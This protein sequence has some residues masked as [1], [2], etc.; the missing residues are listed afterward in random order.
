MNWKI[1]YGDGLTFSDHNG[2]PA[3]SPAFNVQAIV[4]RD[5][6]VGRQVLQAYD[7]YYY[8][9]G[10]WHGSKGDFSM[11]EQVINNCQKIEAVR[12]GRVIRTSLFKEI[13]DNAINDP[14][15]PIKSGRKKTE[16]P[17][18]AMQ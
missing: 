9:D 6:D 3:D 14:D 8:M 1:Y 7:W 13:F 11:L 16:T 17:E 4:V 15:F 10:E 12:P 5:L 2:D 18:W